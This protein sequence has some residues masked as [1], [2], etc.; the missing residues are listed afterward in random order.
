MSTTPF[1]VLP[2]P[3]PPPSSHSK[4]ADKTMHTDSLVIS[5]NPPPPKLRLHNTENQIQI[6]LLHLL[7]PTKIVPTP[8]VVNQ[9]RTL[10]HSE[11]YNFLL[12]LFFFQAIKIAL[13]SLATNLLSP[14]N[15]VPFSAATWRPP[16]SPLCEPLDG[17]LA[18]NIVVP[19]TNNTNTKTRTNTNTVSKWVHYM[20]ASWQYIGPTHLSKGVALITGY[21]LHSA[22][23]IHKQSDK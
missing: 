14:A 3:S 2:S 18:Q 7:M 13:F 10:S 8:K 4:P 12:L 1:S 11:P 5:K 21:P 23:Q 19:H 15:F 6:Q 17:T 9:L 20:W 16:F 22:P